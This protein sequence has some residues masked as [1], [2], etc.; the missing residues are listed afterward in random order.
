MLAINPKEAQDLVG[1]FVQYCDDGTRE[2]V[3]GPGGVPATVSG[4]HVE[5]TRE[6]DT[7]P[8]SNG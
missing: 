8:A 1:K 3:H 4:R 7:A 6:I 2:R 5:G